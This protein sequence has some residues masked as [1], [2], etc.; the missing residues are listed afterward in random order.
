M[1]KVLVRVIAMAAVSMM[2]IQPSEAANL[3][4]LAKGAGKLFK[5]AGKKTINHVDDV[6]RVSGS[7]PQKEVPVTNYTVCGACRGTGQV[8]VGYNNYGRPVIY[9]CRQCGGTGKIWLRRP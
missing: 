5:G 2:L 9:Q 4:K 7:S 8:I 3:G 1:N 6:V